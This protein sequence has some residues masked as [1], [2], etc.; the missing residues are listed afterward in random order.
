M[1]KEFAI[2]ICFLAVVY[3]Y[4]TQVITCN[5]LIHLLQEILKG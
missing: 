2:A 4:A 5:S 3:A 1:M